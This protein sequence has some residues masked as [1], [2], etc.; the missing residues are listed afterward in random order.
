MKILVLGFGKTRFRFGQRSACAPRIK[1]STAPSLRQNKINFVF[2]GDKNLIL[3]FP[4]FHV[5]LGN[6]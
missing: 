1:V 2:L 5:G 6:T 3:P 4:F